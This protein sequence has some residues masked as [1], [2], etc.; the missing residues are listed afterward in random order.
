M[1][2]ECSRLVHL[3]T[4]PAGCATHLT[5]LPDSLPAGHGGHVSAEH[6]RGL[7]SCSP[8]SANQRPPTLT[9]THTHT[10]SSPGRRTVAPRLAHG[11]RSAR[12][13]DSA[14]L[15]LLVA[16]PVH[17]I[18]HH[19]PRA[20]PPQQSLTVP[21][22]AQRRAESGSAEHRRRHSCPGPVPARRRGP[23]PGRAPARPACRE[24]QEGAAEGSGRTAGLLRCLRV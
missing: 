2:S 5:Q 9:H 13:R 1:Q 21:G 23:V 18:V 3:K 7:A 12:S 15:P 17:R 24:G 19:Q 6:P 14:Y 8:L 16:Q 20:A 11:R 4:Q 22:F 10:P